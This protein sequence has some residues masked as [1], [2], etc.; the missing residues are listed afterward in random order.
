MPI[1]R[2]ISRIV[3][4]LKLKPGTSRP[5]YETWARTVDLPNVNRLQSVQGFEVLE[6]TGLLGSTDRPPYD[7]IEVLDVADMVLFGQEVASETMKSIAAEFQRWA[8]PVFVT[9]RRLEWEQQ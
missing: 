3:V 9:T 8:D 2:S 6:A 4:L 7:Y 1:A 5:D